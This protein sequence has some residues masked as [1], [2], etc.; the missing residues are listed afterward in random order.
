MPTHLYCLVPAA[1]ELAAPP[2]IRVIAA[3]TVAA[4]VGDARAP[5]LSREAKDAAQ[6][7][8]EHDR[9]VGL[10]LAQGITPVP[11]SLTDPYADDDAAAADVAAHAAK[12]ESALE[13]VRDRVEMTVIVAMGEA[14]IPPSMPARGRAYLEGLRSHAAQASTI[15]ALIDDALARI[16]VATA[17]R[18]EGNRV[19]LSHLVAREHVDSYR[20]FC[21]GVE[22][23]GYRIVMD[24]P[25][26]PY[27]FARF[28]P[29]HGILGA[30][31]ASPA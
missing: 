24:G 8:I 18:A 17:Q 15:A 11:A 9:V 21:R 25:R 27:S 2:A 10:A 3:G 30:Q 28:S 31:A 16:V 7:T 13:R 23:Q 20:E 29:G 6:A 14:P 22:G 12:V 5:R 19:A 1:S 26:A 4:W